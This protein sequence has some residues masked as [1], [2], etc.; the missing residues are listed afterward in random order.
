[1]NPLTS[2]RYP[3]PLSTISTSGT[4]SNG[5]IW[6]SPSIWEI[7]R[8]A[9]RLQLRVRERNGL[10]VQRRAKEDSNMNQQNY[11]NPVAL[12]AEIFTGHYEVELSV[13]AQLGALRD[14]AKAN[15]YLVARR[16]R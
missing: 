16:I 12:Y 5:R 9:T 10:E 8:K 13:H 14:F 3:I 15:D 2:I 1:M 7:V 6:E 4:G 11:L